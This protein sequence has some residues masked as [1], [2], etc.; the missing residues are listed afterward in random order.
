MSEREVVQFVVV[1]QGDRTAPRG[2][3]EKSKNIVPTLNKHLRG[4]NLTKCD[5]R[6]LPRVML[7]NTPLFNEVAARLLYWTKWIA[8]HTPGMTQDL[9]TI[10]ETFGW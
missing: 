7:R 10:V 1:L 9:E 8:H 4:K 5:S 6:P 2:I 3:V